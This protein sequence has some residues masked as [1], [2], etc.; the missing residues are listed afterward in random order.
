V[1]SSLALHRQ[2]NK[3]IN[4]TEEG[5]D[6]NDHT[7]ATPHVDHSYHD[8]SRYIQQGGEVPKHKKAGS[9]FPARLHHMLAD[10]NN[11]HIIAWMVSFGDLFIDKVI[12]SIA[13][14]FHLTSNI[15]I[16]LSLHTY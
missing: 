13:Y 10:P 9:N 12:L 1:I 3:I 2:T 11:S 4:M 15:D 7:D 16:S 8:F 6:D 5:G 14:P